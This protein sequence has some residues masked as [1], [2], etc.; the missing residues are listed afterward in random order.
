MSKSLIS[1]AFPSVCLCFESSLAPQRTSFFVTDS[2]FKMADGC[3]LPSAPP[4]QQGCEVLTSIHG[5]IH[6]KS[7]PFSKLPRGPFKKFC[8][9]LIFQSTTTIKNQKRHNVWGRILSFFISA[10]HFGINLYKNFL[11]LTKFVSQHLIATHG[12]LNR[13]Q[14]RTTNYLLNGRFEL[15]SGG[16]GHLATPRLNSLPSLSPFCR[17]WKI[18]SGIKF[19][20]AC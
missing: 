19:Q 7:R 15:G 10:L 3:C 17:V 20:N 6:Q 13:H 18:Y 1:D 4:S 2:K 9:C 5:H 8:R 14:F 12:H 16:H 11:N